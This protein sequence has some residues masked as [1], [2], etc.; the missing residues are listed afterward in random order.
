MHE[1][2]WGMA[3]KLPMPLNGFAMVFLFGMWF[4][5]NIGVLMV[6]A[7]APPLSSHTPLYTALSPNP[8]TSSSPTTGDGEPLVLLTRLTPPMGRVPEQVL[9]GRRLQVQAVQLCNTRAERGGG[10]ML[11]GRACAEDM[12]LS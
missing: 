3:I 11:I 4:I 7:L 12:Y 9:Q 8:L 1:Q 10:V 6:C 2:A 5:L